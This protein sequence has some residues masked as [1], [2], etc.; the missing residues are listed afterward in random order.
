[1]LGIT[2]ALVAHIPLIG[3]LAPTLAALAY[4]H[5]GL[6]AL[7][8]IRQGAIVTIIEGS[9]TRERLEG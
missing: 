1:M 7:R 9:S 5:Y 8:K 4:V 2:L 6:E 3:L